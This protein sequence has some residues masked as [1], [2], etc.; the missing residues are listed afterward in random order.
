MVH[1][2]VHTPAAH[3]EQS[4]QED[5]ILESIIRDIQNPSFAD[6]RDA[7]KRLVVVFQA[8]K[9][10]QDTKLNTILVSFATGMV[11]IESSVVLTIW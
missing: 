4:L 7:L 6:M 9:I 2:V 5:V 10:S 11:V 8:R 3:R 1:G